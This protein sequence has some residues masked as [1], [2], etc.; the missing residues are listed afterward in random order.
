MRQFDNAE[1]LKV[2]NPA[3]PDDQAG[4]AAPKRVPGSLFQGWGP[5]LMATAFAAGALAISTSH[6]K[7]ATLVAMAAACQDHSA[8]L[9]SSPGYVT[10]DSVNGAGEAVYRVTLSENGRIEALALERSAGDPLLD[11]TAGRIVRQSRY[12]AAVAGCKASA[13]TFLYSVRFEH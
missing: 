13:E 10:P 9:T 2:R 3:R 12:A 5:K 8:R 7:A 6:V 4:I 1:N 11:F